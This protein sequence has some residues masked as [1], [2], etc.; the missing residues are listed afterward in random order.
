[1]NKPITIGAIG[2]V[3]AV[4][5]VVLMVFTL[6]KEYPIQGPVDTPIRLSPQT[7]TTTEE[8]DK[9]GITPTNL[10]DQKEFVL[11][12]AFVKETA[13]PKE[14]QRTPVSEEHSILE[15]VV[16]TSNK[17]SEGVLDQQVASRKVMKPKSPSFAFSQLETKRRSPTWIASGEGRKPGIPDQTYVGRDRFEGFQPNPLKLVS[18]E[19]VSTF[20]M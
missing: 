8:K 10:A 4:S 1:M 3:V 15:E 6:T 11:G 13:A 14:M 2:S 12:E 20:S 18:E 7:T 19:S 17:V 5:F 9:K 16:V